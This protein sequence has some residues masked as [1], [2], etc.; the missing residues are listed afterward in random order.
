[1]VVG[2]RSDNIMVKLHLL[3]SWAHC[4]TWQDQVSWRHRANFHQH[5]KTTTTSIKISFLDIELDLQTFVIREM[6]VF[7]IH[8]EY[9][10]EE[11]K[12]RVR[13]MLF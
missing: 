11:P 12:K 9:L 8:D 10:K 4:A 7:E 5:V 13:S 2:Y 6:L 1:M 3:Q